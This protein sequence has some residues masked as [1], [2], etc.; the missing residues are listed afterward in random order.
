MGV[1]G[2]V[3]TCPS[4]LIP[5]YKR[6]KQEAKQPKIYHA[7]KTNNSRTQRYYLHII[8]IYNGITKESVMTHQKAGPSQAVPKPKKIKQSRKEKKKTHQRIIHQGNSLGLD[9]SGNSYRFVAALLLSNSLGPSCAGYPFIGASAIPPVGMGSNPGGAPLLPSGCCMPFWRR[10]RRSRKR[11]ATMIRATP[12]TPPTTPPAM[13]PVLL[14]VPSGG[15]LGLGLAG[16]GSSGLVG[17]VGEGVDDG[18]IRAVG[19]LVGGYR[20]ALGSQCNKQPKVNEVSK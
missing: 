2:R 13:A 14:A 3:Y 19:R 20:P 4:I 9:S 12:A 6:S 10:R 11:T 5:S 18:E 7:I 15:G 1:V 17:A 8:S 16:G